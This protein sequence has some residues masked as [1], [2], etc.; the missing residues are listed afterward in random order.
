ME[1][2]QIDLR[3]YKNCL[4]NKSFL[5]ENSLG[6]RDPDETD[7]DGHY[8]GIID[9]FTVDYNKILNSKSY[10][11][12]PHKTQVFPLSENFNVRDRLI[13]S[14]GVNSLAVRIAEITGLNSKLVSAA[15]WMH[16]FGHV[17][18]GHLGERAISAISGKKFRHEIF[19]VIVAQR[20]ERQ[21]RGLNLSF[22]VLEGA[23]KHSRGD[24]TLTFSFDSH[25]EHTLIM[26]SDKIEYTFADINDCLRVGRLSEKDLPPE[27]FRLGNS[28]RLR[29]ARCEFALI[30]ESAKLGYICFHESEEARDF[31]QLRQ[32]MYEHV[33]HELGKEED[34]S[35]YYYN[36]LYVVDFFDKFKFFEI[37]PILL[38]AL[39]TDE[40]VQIVVELS[41]NFT[42]KDLD[43]MSRLGF[44]EI[45]RS[46][47][48]DIKIDLNDPELDWGHSKKIKL[49]K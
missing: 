24:K 20:I 35:K 31:E 45:A 47:S 33:Y 48:G 3:P 8:A 19:S 4:Q 21:G 17:P 28:Q 23:L 9:P 13:H 7:D 46:L 26:F 32:W 44:V 10:R 40:E 39:M 38:L 14:A 1:R 41:K 22:E 27:W 6:R 12:L 36:M 43:Y 15:S 25:L 5:A 49:V 29:L 37:D 16:D 34:Q 18:F 42:I 2:D 30:K 11:R